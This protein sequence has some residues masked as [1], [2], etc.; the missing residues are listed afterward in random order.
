MAGTITVEG[1]GRLSITLDMANTP[2]MPVEPGER[3]IRAGVTV[4]FA[5]EDAE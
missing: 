5:L 1:E 3:V 2:P 4:T